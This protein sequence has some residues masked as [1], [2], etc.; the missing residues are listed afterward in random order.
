[1][2]FFDLDIDPL[3]KSPIQSDEL[4]Y[5][6]EPLIGDYMEMETPAEV[7]TPEISDEQLEELKSIGYLQGVDSDKD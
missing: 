4:I 2:D 1:M 7:A 3:E 5:T 6:L